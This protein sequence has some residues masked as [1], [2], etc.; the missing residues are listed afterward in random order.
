MPELT[1]LKVRLLITEQETLH[2][3]SCYSFHMRNL[4]LVLLLLARVTSQAKPI[5]YGDAVASEVTNL[6]W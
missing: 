3:F 4:I 1:G 6:R 5:N 2:K